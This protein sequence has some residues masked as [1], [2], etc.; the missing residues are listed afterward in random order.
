MD[1]ATVPYIQKAKNIQITYYD[2]STRE[3]NAKVYSN[4]YFQLIILTI[5]NLGTSQY[6]SWREGVRE[7]WKNN[8]EGVGAEKVLAGKV[9]FV[10]LLVCLPVFFSFFV[11]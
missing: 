1:I 8:C 4:D 9:V 7:R 3:Q 11:I 2:I 6:L 5:S 10:Y